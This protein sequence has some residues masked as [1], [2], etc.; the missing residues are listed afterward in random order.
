MVGPGP[1]RWHGARV[2]LRSSNS[3]FQRHNPQ[4]CVEIFETEAQSLSWTWSHPA[5]CP[6]AFLGF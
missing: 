4:N 6:W 5:L 2:G 1:G 3:L